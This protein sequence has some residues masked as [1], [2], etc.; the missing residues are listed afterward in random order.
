MAEP[1]NL[2]LKT[3]DGRH[4]MHKYYPAPGR[5]SGLALLLPGDH[6]GM[7]APLL[8]YPALAL[9]K[10]GWDT[11]ALTYGYQSAGRP[12]SMEEIPDTVDE[13]VRALEGSGLLPLSLSV[14]V[15]AQ[16]A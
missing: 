8:Y 1:F 2:E 11:L 12:I 10:Q 3:A 13:V 6:Y 5:P 9:R 4:L 15:V 14:R 7:D 16:Q